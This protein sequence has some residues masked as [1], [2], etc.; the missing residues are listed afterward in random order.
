MRITLYGGF[1]MHENMD[2]KSLMKPHAIRKP[3]LIQKWLSGTPQA[4]MAMAAERI[5]ANVL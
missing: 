2:G 5:P 3:L 1:F 4:L